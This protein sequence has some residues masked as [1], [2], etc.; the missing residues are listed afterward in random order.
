MVAGPITGIVTDKP[1]TEAVEGETP[2]AAARRPSQQ[3]LL[4]V[5]NQSPPNFPG[6]RNASIVSKSTGT[7]SSAST[8]TI[9]NMGGRKDSASSSRMANTFVYSLRYLYLADNRLSDEA[10]EELSLLTELRVLNLS[11]NDLYDVPPRA[12]SR[13]PQLN[14]LYLSGNELTSLPAEDLEHIPLLKVLHL[15]GNK[16]QT[17]PAELGK[18][19]KLL[20][21]DV[22]NNAL[23]YNIS[24]WPYDWN[25]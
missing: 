7:E 9:M 8:V 10:F 14:E 2:E 12:L 11:Y 15:N 4:S 20:V 6:S 18:I 1:A 23:K 16:F 13:M 17:L 21:L 24:N 22:G 25:W 19:R 5:N 3:G